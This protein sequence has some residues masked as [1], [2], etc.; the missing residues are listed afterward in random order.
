V[1]YGAGI[2]KRA[3]RRNGLPYLIV[4]NDGDIDPGIADYLIF[5]PSL[6]GMTAPRLLATFKEEGGRFVFTDFVDASPAKAAGIRTGDALLAL[7]GVPVFTIEEIKLALFYKSKGDTILA[8][9]ARQRF[10][11]GEKV[12]TVEVKL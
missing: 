7:D 8:T 12:M 2:P 4:L 6:D 10:L 1:V 11:L 9:V 3:F 5:P